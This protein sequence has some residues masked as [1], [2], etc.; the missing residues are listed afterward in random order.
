MGLRFTALD[1]RDVVRTAP[2]GQNPDMSY[3]DGLLYDW[4]EMAMDFR[5]GVGEHDYA[6][7]SGEALYLHG[8]MQGY[9]HAY[10]ELNAIVEYVRGDGQHRLT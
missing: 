10:R 3:L 1:V 5:D 6:G 8:Q 9:Q 2:E 4:I 7:K